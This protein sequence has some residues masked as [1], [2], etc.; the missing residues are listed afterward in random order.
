MHVARLYRDV[1]NSPVK[2]LWAH[3]GWPSPEEPRSGS[4]PKV[5]AM[6]DALYEWMTANVAEAAEGYLQPRGV[7]NVRLGGATGDGDP[8]KYG[9]VIV[10]PEEWRNEQRLDD[11]LMAHA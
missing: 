2:P 4:K 1:L 11:G 3:L 7:S 8:G 5:A 6:L 10:G 9:Y